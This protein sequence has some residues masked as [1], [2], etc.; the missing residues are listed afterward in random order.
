MFNKTLLAPA[1][2]GALICMPQQAH[3]QA[4]ADAPNQ[5]IIVTGEKATRSLQDTTAS[6]AVTTSA[7]IERENV[8]TL[9]EIFER[10]AN[11]AATYGTAGFTI[12]GVA[13]NGVSGGGDAPL[14]TIY[15]DGAPLPSSLT[16]VGPTDTWDIAQVEIFRGPQSTLQGLNALAGAIVI[17]TQDPTFDWDVRGRAIIAE[18]DTTS[19]AVAGGGPI[20]PGE[21]AFRMAAEKRDSDGF[22]KNITRNDRENPLDSISVRGKLLWTPSA[23]EGLEARLGY[24]H[25]ERRGGY[26]FSYAE[27]TSPDFFDN[28]IAT[29]DY[30]NRSDTDADIVNLEL[31]YPIGDGISLSSVSNFSDTSLDRAYDGDNSAEPTSYGLSTT[32]SKTFTQELRL[33]YESD[34]LSGLI[35]AFYYNR[36][37]K[38]DSQSLTLVPTPVTTVAGLLQSNGLPAATAKMI[39]NL[40]ASAL[41]QIPVQ[42]AGALPM[43]VETM[44]I[45]ADGRLALTDQL[46]LLAGFRYDR[47]QNVVSVTQTATFAGTY[48]NPAAFGA[49]GSPFYNAI[50]GINAGVGGLVA[51]AAGSSPESKRTFNAFLPKLGL[52]MAWTPDLS[53]AFVVQRGYRSGGTSSNTAR[54]QAF[55]YD[56]EYTWNYE[57]S[58]RSAWLDGRLTLNANAFYVDWKDQQTSVNFGLNLY[59][60]HTVN[61]GSSHLYGFEIEANHRVS[62]A[63]DLY[64]SLGHVRTKFDEFIT[65]I[66]TVDD[67][68]GLEF[69]YS[70]HWT[71]AG[72][73][74]LRFGG[75]FT[76]NLNAN[77]RSAVFGD[78]T[79]PQE[80]YRVGGRT[81]V[82]A[83]IGYQTDQFGI[84]VFANNLLDENYFQYN[85]FSR[86]IALLGDP[87]VF[88]LLLETRF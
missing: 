35:G 41:P 60:S 10:T 79:R 52:D 58:L 32:D 43:K 31:D 23:I 13:D 15:I 55:P 72:G 51:Q 70:P 27:T 78:V 64:A 54:S 37:Q 9:S 4:V 67:L 85:N 83:K 16:G 86:G 25:F 24:T 42:Y 48:P 61:A 12:R 19:F 38:G 39:A 36:D 82:N 40:Y 77:Y 47:E 87:Q 63:F 34:R 76:F 49:P 21:L 44:A 17:R 53:T 57:L 62:S 20:I 7:R 8:Q 2:V 75:G 66:G 56:P 69:P 73:A 81:V 80:P 28:R 11:V 65:D 6:V 30:P 71:V 26:I 29:G 14:A 88:G 33:N 18:Y 45:F 1:A 50:A 5:E 74:N 46:K 59:D 84:S 3:A 22:I 68:S